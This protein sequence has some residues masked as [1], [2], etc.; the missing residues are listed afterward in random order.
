MSFLLGK[1]IADEIKLSIKNEIKNLKRMPNY[2]IL[3]NH[4]DE[5]SLGY[6]KIQEKTCLELGINCT[7]ISMNNNEEEYIKTIKELNDNPLVDAILVTRPLDKGLNEKNILNALNPLKDVDAIN[8]Y[9]LGKL[10]MDEA[11][12]V[13][14]TAEAVLVMLKHYNIELK[15]KNVLVIGRSLSVGKPCAMLL[16]KENATVTIAHSRTSNLDDMLKNYDIV[17]VSIGK[18]QFID[19]SKMKKDAIV[20]DCGIHYLENGIVGDVKISDNVKFISKVPGG[21]GSITTSLLMRNI[22][23]CYK[24]N[25]HD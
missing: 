8:P 5:S 23:K 20:I 10:F 1:V 11:E 16:L 21:I 19:S 25:N 22:L 7:I 13:P 12:I 14:N 6:C 4:N 17:V 3:L 18:P 24:V 15:G 2:Y 9:S